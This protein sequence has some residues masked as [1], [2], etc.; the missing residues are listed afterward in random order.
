M[1]TINN[2]STGFQSNALK[3]YGAPAP[4][5]TKVTATTDISGFDATK[6]KALTVAEAAA[7]TTEQVSSISTTAMAGLTEASWVC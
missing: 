5:A 6:I 3:T 7:L 2:L 4:A 1:A